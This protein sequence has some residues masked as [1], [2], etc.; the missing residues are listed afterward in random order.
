MSVQD[1]F[2]A[3]F[4][5]MDAGDIR[6]V[7]A[8][9]GEALKDRPRADVFMLTEDPSGFVVRH[10]DGSVFVPVPAPEREEVYFR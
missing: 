4:P 9:L 5:S 2:K 3:D 1:R 6:Q 10:K 7:E 8:T